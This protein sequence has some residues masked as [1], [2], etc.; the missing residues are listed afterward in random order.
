MRFAK[1][2]VAV[3]AAA[4]LSGGMGCEEQPSQPQ[5]APQN[6]DGGQYDNQQQGDGGQ[7]PQQQ[8]PQQP[9][10]PQGSGGDY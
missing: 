7:Q 9:T 6:Q 4:A 10:Q 2:F 8:E 1:I 5:T 3:I